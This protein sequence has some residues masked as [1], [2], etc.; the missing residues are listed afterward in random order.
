[1]FVKEGFCGIKGTYSR[2]LVQEHNRPG[3]DYF[4]V[5]T[6]PRVSQATPPSL[7]SFPLDR[8]CAVNS[9]SLVSL[10]LL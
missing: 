3:G 1:M 2:F 9:L 6:H 4:P 10:F 8:P 7:C 5:A